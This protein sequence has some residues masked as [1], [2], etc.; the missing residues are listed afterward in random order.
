M[1]VEDELRI[2]LERAGEAVPLRPIEAEDLVRRG[3]ASRRRRMALAAVGAVAALATTGI[4][5]IQVIERVDRAPISPI[6][7]STEEPTPE[8][9]MRLRNLQVLVFSWINAL[10]RNEP[11]VAWD[12][13]VHSGWAGYEGFADARSLHE[14]WGAWADAT[15]LRFRTRAISLI[16]RDVVIVT[17]TGD[18]S[19][20]E[21]RGPAAASV[22][23]VGGPD[24]EALVSLIEGP[25]SIEFV[26]PTFAAE[27]SGQTEMPAVGPRPEFEVR[28]Y[29]KVKDALMLIEGPETSSME[30]AT[31]DRSPAASTIT[32][33]PSDPLDPGIY[34]ATVVVGG[35]RDAIDTWAV[36]FEVR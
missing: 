29:P 23:V 17:M 19:L 31:V 36:R 20:G 21:P 13:M 2:G 1:K 26:T 16:D 32:Y 9:E 25:G 22:L 34:T 28:T 11:D 14:S 27:G 3:R 33:T 4:L 7:R 5:A 8:S 15:D 24:G 35:P 30:P 12:Y 10:A 18:I 6:D